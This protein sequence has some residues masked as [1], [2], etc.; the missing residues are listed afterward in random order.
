MSLDQDQPVPFVVLGGC[1]RTDFFHRML[2]QTIDFASKSSAPGGAAL[3]KAL[4]TIPVPGFRQFL[5]APRGL[6]V[7]AAISR[8]DSSDAFVGCVLEAWLEANLPLASLGESFLDAQGI[9]RRRIVAGEQAFHGRWSMDE[10]LR[11]A[12]LFCAQHSAD[13]DDVALLLCCLTSRAPVADAP[14]AS[15]APPGGGAEA[16]R[17]AS[18]PTPADGSPQPPREADPE[19]PKPRSRATAKKPGALRRAGTGTRKPRPE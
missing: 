3:V 11:L 8:F 1:L 6:Q 14:E 4:A 19:T 18:P 12:D 5:R 15:D 10:V 2:L 9:P 13:R 17:D 7:R 16:A